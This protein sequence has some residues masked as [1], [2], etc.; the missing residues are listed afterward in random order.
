MRMKSICC[1]LIACFSFV[2]SSVSYA[3]PLQNG[4]FSAGLT[5]WTYSDGVSA[6]GGIVTLDDSTGYSTLFQNVDVN[7]GT[8][9]IFSFDFSAEIVPIDGSSSVLGFSDAFF[10]SLYFGIAAPVGLFDLNAGSIFNQVSGSEITGR[11]PLGSSASDWFHFSYTFTT[12]LSEL[13][14]SPTFDLFDLNQELGDGRAYI[15]NVSLSESPGPIQ[16]PEPSSML[17]LAGGLAGLGVFW[18]K[19]IVH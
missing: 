16:M 1:A 12:G 17:L 6:A 5:S 15:A 2:I 13:Y 9:Y 18:I 14:V 10:P 4:D 3:Y 11:T 19:K 8:T 7:A